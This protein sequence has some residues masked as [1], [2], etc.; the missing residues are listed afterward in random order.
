MPEANINKTKR[1]SVCCNG[2]HCLQSTASH[3]CLRACLCSALSFTRQHRHCLIDDAETDCMHAV[4]ASTLL[5]TFAAVQYCARGSLHDV[6]IR[7]GRSKV[8]HPMF[9][10]LGQRDSQL[11]LLIGPTITCRHLAGVPSR[12]WYKVS[13]QECLSCHLLPKQTVVSCLFLLIWASKV[14]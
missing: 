9:M 14:S 8:I 7:A 11:C 2:K 13:C 5:P 10:L 12:Q 1:I 6:L 4:C 3:A